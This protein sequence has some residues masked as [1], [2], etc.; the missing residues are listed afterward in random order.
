MERG[1][2]SLEAIARQ[3]AV[4]GCVHETFGAAVAM[5]QS[6]NA[7]DAR[8][9]AAMRPIARDELRHADLAW[10]VARW[11]DLRLAPAARARVARARCRAARTLLRRVSRKVDPDLVAHLGIPSTHHAS[12]IALDLAES[13]WEAA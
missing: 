1:V 9:R 2:R 8:V 13:L 11:L 4:E 5:V 7:S 12:A 6:M 10:A 3:N